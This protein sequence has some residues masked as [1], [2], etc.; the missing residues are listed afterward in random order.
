M[1]VYLEKGSV[2]CLLR[3]PALL[4]GTGW[5]ISVR[6]KQGDTTFNE[7]LTSACSSLYLRML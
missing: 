2:H 4:S 3:P 6:L 7:N 1:R 5:S